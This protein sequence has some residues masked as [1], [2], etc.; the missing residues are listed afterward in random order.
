MQE[1]LKKGDTV[2]KDTFI[3]TLPGHSG[4]L[5]DISVTPV[6]QT[7]WKD[8]TKREDYQIYTIKTKTPLGLNVEDGPL[9]ILIYFVSL[10]IIMNRLY[11]DNDF[12][13][14]FLSF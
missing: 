8:P 6:Y 12:R 2:S 4:F 5:N 13:T 1:S 11:L 7:D 9:A 10:I 3:S 14:L